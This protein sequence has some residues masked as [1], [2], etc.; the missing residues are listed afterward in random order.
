MALAVFTFAGEAFEVH[1]HLVQHAGSNLT[2]ALSV[3]EGEALPEIGG[4]YDPGQVHGVVA[5]YLGA[6]AQRLARMLDQPQQHAFMAV[7]P[8]WIGHGHFTSPVL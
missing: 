8:V 4:A 1:G 5:G 2:L 3:D 6:L 7:P